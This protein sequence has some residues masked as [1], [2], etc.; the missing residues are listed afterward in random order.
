MFKKIIFVSDHFADEFLGGAELSLQALI[1]TCPL[2]YEKLSAKLVSIEFINTHT[3]CFWVFG[4]FSKMKYGLSSL[5][6]EKISYAILEFDYKYCV[7]RSQ[8][9]HNK[10]EGMDCNCRNPFLD[11]FFANAK[12][13]W[14]MSQ[15]QCEW[16]EMKIPAILSTPRSILSSLFDDETLKK[17]ETL[18]SNPKNDSWAVIYSASV[19]KGFDNTIAYCQE[20]KIEPKV[21][22][23]LKYEDLLVELSKCRG[24]VY[25]PIGGDTCPRAVIEAKL[26]GCELK[27]NEFVEHAKESWF[28]CD[29]N[30]TRL[31]LEKNKSMFWEGVLND[32]EK[33]VNL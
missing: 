21:L 10:F 19:I 17:I 11:E 33:A 32:I 12:S 20:N 15:R 25:M 26:L 6:A 18:S 9:L 13:L 28:D 2:P 24:M 4:N 5:L 29:V 23:N 3:D 16:Y 14:F 27:V 7:Y 22:R 1:D 30:L 8:D 31:Y